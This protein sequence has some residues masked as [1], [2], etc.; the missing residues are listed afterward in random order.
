[1]T[2]PPAC[3]AP[4]DRCVHIWRQIPNPFAD[5]PL[6]VFECKNCHIVREKL[7]PPY[8]SIIPHRFVKKEETR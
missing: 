2:N 5:K 4:P 3:S 8:F 6:F 1:M 7:E